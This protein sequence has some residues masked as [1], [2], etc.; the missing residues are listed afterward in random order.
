MSSARPEARVSALG[1]SRAL[2][3][4][5]AAEAAPWVAYAG[6]GLVALQ[7][8]AVVLSG[9]INPLYAL[10]LL[11]VPLFAVLCWMSLPAAWLVTL[12]AVPFSSEVVLPGTAS[13]LW[14]PTEPM[15]LI[16]LGVWGV[17]AVLRGA[18]RIPRSPLLAAIGALGLVAVLS[19]LGSRYYFLSIKA[20]LSTAWFVA[21]A[22]LFPYLH[23]GDKGLA[24]RALLVLAVAGT[25]FAAYGLLFLVRH[26]LMRWTA[27]AMGRPFFNEHGTYSTFL[28][29]AVAALLVLAFTARRALWRWLAVA[30]AGLVTL[31]AVLSLARAAYLGL[32]ALFAVTLWHLIRTGRTRSVFAVIVVVLAVGFGMARFQAGEFVGLYAASITQ[33][34]ELSNLE[35]I[36]RWL[37]A[38]NMVRAHPLL[39]VGYG[40]YDDNY[41]S[42]RVLT[43]RTEERFRRMGV[44]NEYFKVLSETGWL[45]FAALGALLLLIFREGSRAIRRA[46][47]PAD[48]WL[49]LGALAGVSSYL[50]HGFFNS[51]TGNDKLG[52]PL[53]FLISVVAMLAARTRRAEAALPA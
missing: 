46:R 38:A 21:F 49:A 39:G 50:V 28:S 17:R 2:L 15:M 51:Y 1:I 26:G 37:A 41:Y 19:A 23:G 47:S 45:G 48:R 11:F 12:A 27:N 20:I 18:H 40:T 22:F 44:H 9:W 32:A 53:W 6:A 25:F 8:A 4:I 43:L 13:A 29:F 34:G 3:G 7:L 16:F 30:A 36:S 5:P 10:G 24:R 52:V 14:I 33:P 35:R 31:A 42:Y